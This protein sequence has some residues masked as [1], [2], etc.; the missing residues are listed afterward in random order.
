LESQPFTYQN[1]INAA[2]LT[3][4]NSPTPPLAGSQQYLIYVQYINYLAIPT[5]ENQRNVLWNELWI[6]EP[7]YA[8]LAAGQTSIAL[9]SDFKFLGGGYIRIT[10]PNSTG[11]PS[12]IRPIPVKRLPEIELNPFQIKKEFYISGNIQN[13]FELILGWPI[14]PGDA[15]V[16]A[17][18]SFR[19]Y[20]YAN[21]AQTNVAGILSNPNDMPEM[22]DP[23]YV[24]KKVTAAVAA[25]NYNLNL[26]TIYENQATDCLAQMMQGNEM[27]TNYQD[28]YVK[29]VDALLGNGGAMQNRFNS[30]YWTR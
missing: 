20:K 10:Y 27:G 24:F 30:N 7:N 14:Q 17:T 9:P 1:I 21:I 22:S 6:D 4:L 5:W 25:A 26:Y 28:D 15:E 3:A 11:A 23:S 16:G 2:Q 12:S 29:D 13:G 19:Y 18:I 8:K